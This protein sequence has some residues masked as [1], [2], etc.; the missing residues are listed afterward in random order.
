VSIVAARFRRVS[1]ELQRDNTSLENQLSNIDRYCADHGYETPDEFLYT[2]V[3]TGVEFWDMPELQRLLTKAPE[4]AFQVVVVD[5]TDRMVRGEILVA[6]MSQLARYHI[7]LESVKQNIDDT[8]EGK[9]VLLVTSWGSK[10]EWDRIKQRT[11]EGRD[12]YVRKQKKILGTDA[13]YGYKKVDGHYI[14]NDDVIYID[15]N[16]TEWTERKVVEW[17][18]QKCKE[19]MTLYTITQTLT[20]LGIPTRRDGRWNQYFVTQLLRDEGYEKE[21]SDPNNQ[22]IIARIRQL[23]AEGMTP[24]DIAKLL[25]EEGV[26]QQVIPQ[27]WRTSTVF[28]M[29]R[30][31]TYIGNFYA[32]RRS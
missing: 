14:Y 22:P 24:S 28:T 23:A 30:N 12:N 31:Q 8:P 4:G 3:M 6:I 7:R 25:N 1:S 19:G 10:R 29:L 5:H 9:L 32:F 20:D 27:V 2:E 17:C 16:G 21:C 15:R 26:S 18:F 13:C 11:S